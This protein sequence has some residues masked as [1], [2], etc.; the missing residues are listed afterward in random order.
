[1]FALIRLLTGSL[2]ILFRSRAALTAE[3]MALR[4][5]L[6]VYHRTAPAR[7]HLTR[8]ER[9]L[10]A[11]ILYRWSGW[12]RSL[13]VVKPETVIKWHRRAFGLVWRWKSRGG[14]PN[15]RSEIRGLIREMARSNPTWGAPRIHA[16]LL[17]LDFEVSERTVSRFLA[18]IRP[19]PARPGSQTW[20]SFL[21][22][23][24]KGIVAVDMFTVPTIRFQVL[25]IFVVLSL[26]RRR[27]VFANVT[28]NPTAEWLG[29][30]VV[31]A[32]PWDTAPKFLVRDRDKAY[33]FEF[34]RRTKGLG[35]REVKTA[36]E[37]PLMNAYCERLIGTLRRECFDHVI[38]LNERHARRLL[39]EFC[40]WYNQD[41]CHLSLA[42]D[43][44]EHRPVEPPV[45][46]KVVALPRLGGLHHRY[47]RRAA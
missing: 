23:H 5:Q 9:A 32:F 4:H 44:P 15:I 38:V 41:R 10:W 6:G 25:Y 46:G 45:M 1:M 12:R 35:I 11:L 27:L 26:D 18:R 47:T 30:Q 14:R 22:N 33:G 17:K 36:I 42:K 3:I 19:K 24:A 39:A 16:E 40:A 13:I 28:V 20:A 31:N 37:A 43:A 21:R 29:Q 34:S 7:P 8:W 2:I